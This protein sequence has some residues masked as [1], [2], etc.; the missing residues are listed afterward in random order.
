ML[1]LDLL[2]PTKQQNP[3]PSG[4][5]APIDDTQ[6]ALLALMPDSGSF[7]SLY[8]SLRNIYGISWHLYQTCPEVRLQSFSTNW[9]PYWDSWSCS[10]ILYQ[11]S[12]VFWVN[13]VVQSALG[14]S[15]YS[16]S[17]VYLLVFSNYDRSL[18]SFWCPSNLV[19]ADHSPSQS[20][21]SIARVEKFF[22]WIL[23]YSIVSLPYH[24]H[25]VQNYQILAIWINYF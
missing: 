5:Y 16:P 14:S 6:I 7:Q 13:N 10:F 2:S 18:D 24:H 21:C 17:W 15:F 19:W 8:G 4:S 23:L 12:W 25:W 1:N 22:L 11:P 20:F 9:C 3:T